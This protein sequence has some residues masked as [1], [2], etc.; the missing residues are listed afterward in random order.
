[1]DIQ[2]IIV[3][4]HPPGRRIEPLQPPHSNLI[5]LIC[6]IV[7][8]SPLTLTHPP[9]PAL[10]S[11]YQDPIRELT[12]QASTSQ[13]QTPPAHADMQVRG[14]DPRYAP[15]HDVHKHH[16]REEDG[17][18]DPSASIDVH[19]LTRTYRPFLLTGIICF[20]QNA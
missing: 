10:Q 17:R 15:T 18:R 6:D 7:S 4:V 16:T 19:H 11:E 20:T 9:H 1:M 5:G 3:R 2:V 13:L 12:R 8:C 14:Q